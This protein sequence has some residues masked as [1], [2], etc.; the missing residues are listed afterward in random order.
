VT[1]VLCRDFV[2]PLHPDV[3]KI[4]EFLAWLNRIP[5]AAWALMT[6]IAVC[7]NL[8]IG[9][10]TRRGEAKAIVLLVLP[11]IMSISFSLIANIDSPRGGFVRVYPD[12]LKSSRSLSKSTHCKISDRSGWHGSVKS[13]QK[14]K[15]VPDKR[16]ET[17][18][19]PK[20]PAG[21]RAAARHRVIRTI[22]ERST[23]SCCP[24][25]TC[26]A[27]GSVSLLRIGMCR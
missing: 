13:L 18:C 11:F 17:M 10:G 5:M 8:L 16:S 3:G 25:F 22:S 12:N 15:R 23:S 20:D 14:H 24:Q 26:C 27:V 19:A 9:Y 1:E 21:C 2:N 6:A 4:D 7:C